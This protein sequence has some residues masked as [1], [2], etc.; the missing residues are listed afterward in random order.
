VVLVGVLVASAILAVRAPGLHRHDLDVAAAARAAAGR[1][2]LAP[3]PLSEELAAAGATVWVSNPLDAFGSGDQAAYLAFLRAD[4]TGATR[5]LE[6][7]DVVIALDGSSQALL[8]LAHGYRA[9][10][11]VGPYEVL[12]QP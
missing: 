9:T 1:V 10:T 2:V 12:A 11:R 6:Q 4:A 3:E 8:A 7:A 5:A